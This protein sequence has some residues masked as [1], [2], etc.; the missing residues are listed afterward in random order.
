M[1]LSRLHCVTP[2]P[3]GGESIG[4]RLRSCRCRQG[5]CSV[6]MGRRCGSGPGRSTFV[7]VNVESGADRAGL[8]EA[9]GVRG[10]RLPSRHGRKAYL[11]GSSGGLPLR[12]GVEGV[13]SST[14]AAAQ[15]MGRKPCGSKRLF[16]SGASGA[17]H[18]GGHVWAALPP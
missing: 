3:S 8:P 2:P 16:S 17:R 14:Y 1:G 7:A 18:G 9:E 13:G 6:T 12:L 5:R 10:L 4:L 11:L 15:R